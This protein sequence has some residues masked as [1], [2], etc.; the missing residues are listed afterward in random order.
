MNLIDILRE[1]KVPFKRHG[2]H[3]HTT[4]DHIQFD[5]PFCSKNT[6]KYRLG[7]SLSKHYFTCWSCG[8]HNRIETLAELTGLP[9]YKCKQLLKGIDTEIP[10]EQKQKPG[11]LI[12]PKGLGPL[13]PV[14]KK[15]LKGRNYSPAT[16]EKIWGIQGIGMAS[17]MAWSIFIPIHHNGHLVSWT[18]RA[19][20]E[21]NSRYTSAKCTQEIIPHKELL[22]GEDY[23]EQTIVVHEGPTDV[24]R[25]G[26]GSVAT[27]GTALTRSQVLKISKYPKRIICFDKDA[28][29][30]SNKL[31][32]LLCVFPGDTYEI[33]LD[34]KDPGSSTV[35]EISKIREFL[36]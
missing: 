35:E 4:A 18:C 26:P 22:Y 36:Q 11:K 31:C 34:S 21:K 16:L 24:W 3:K 32:D 17:K 28:K 7:L 29:G 9:A 5:C 1:H 20:G 8:F 23:C 14:H 30:Y 13:L 2:E 27:F 15:Y 19:I 33:C 25:T 12:L 10:A 6:G